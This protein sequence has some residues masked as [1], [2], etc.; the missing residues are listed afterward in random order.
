[1]ARTPK[2]NE[3]ILGKMWGLLKTIHM[4]GKFY[5]ALASD[6]KLQKYTRE[7]EKSSKELAKKVQQRS[8]RDPVFR[9][10]YDRWASIYDWYIAGNK[11][12]K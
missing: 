9:K 10:H 2:M 3:G 11:P 1:M 5:Q 7:F 4:R 12:Q 8:D 6:K